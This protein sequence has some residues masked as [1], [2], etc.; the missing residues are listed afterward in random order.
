[1]RHNRQVFRKRIDAQ[2]CRTSLTL[3]GASI[4]TTNVKYR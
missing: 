3:N 1:M 2:K 4:L